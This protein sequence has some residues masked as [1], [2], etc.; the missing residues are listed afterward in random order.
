MKILLA[1]DGSDYSDAAVDVVAERPWPEGSTIKIISAVEL[2]YLTAAEP[3][4]LPDSYYAQTEKVASEQAESA[5]KEARHRLEVSREKPIE[6]IGEVRAGRAEDVI[7]E[8]AEKW[9]ADLIVMGSHGYRGFTRF[10]LGSVSHAVATHAP[11]SIEIVR[12]RS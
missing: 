12:R 3:W 8:E 11:C 5:V 1:V 9:G 6:I 10:L 2:P 4:A 7:I